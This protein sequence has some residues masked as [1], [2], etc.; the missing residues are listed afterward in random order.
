[1]LSIGKIIYMLKQNALEN[2]IVMLL[3]DEE[4]I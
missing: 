1:M 3:Y 4:E 2:E